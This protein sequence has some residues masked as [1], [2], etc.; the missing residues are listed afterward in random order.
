VN[1][2]ADPQGSGLVQFY[3][4]LFEAIRSVDENH[5]LFLDGN[6][7]TIDF[8]ALLIDAKERWKNT[9]HALH[10]VRFF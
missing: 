5:T 10:D 2:P 7:Y 4:H 3:D 8:S 9:A 6:T 1:E